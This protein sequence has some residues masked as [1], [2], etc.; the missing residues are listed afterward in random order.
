[1]RITWDAET[2]IPHALI[3]M[4]H[5]FTAHLHILSW[6]TRYGPFIRSIFKDPIFVGSENRVVWTHWKWSSDTRIHDFE[7]K[8]DRNRTCSVFIRH[9]SWKMKGT[10]KFC[11]ISLWSFWPQIEDSLLVLKIGSCE[12]TTNDL[13]TFSPQK[14]NL[15]IGLY[16]RLLP[17]FGTT[18][19]ILVLWIW[20]DTRNT[21]RKIGRENAKAREFTNQSFMT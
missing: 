2:E 4:P 12:H 8:P 10:D 1:M 9:F 21:K 3:M 5:A 20:W 7:K 13:P 19:R 6:C 17:I 14:Q 11:M 15:G 16:E 18:N